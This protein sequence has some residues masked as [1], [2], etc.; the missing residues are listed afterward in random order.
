M[1]FFFISESHGRHHGRD[2]ATT[3]TDNDC[4]SAGRAAIPRFAQLHYEKI[5]KRTKKSRYAQKKYLDRR[6]AR[7]KHTPKHENTTPKRENTPQK[8]ENTFSHLRARIN[9]NEI[10]APGR[11]RR[12]ADP[13]AFRRRSA[14]VPP[15][16]RTR[17]AP[18]LH[19]IRTGAAPVPR[20]CRTGT[21][22][23]PHRC[24][25]GAALVP[26]PFRSESARVPANSPEGKK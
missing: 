5:E 17:S 20:R 19:A 18:V 4:P 1:I 21:A 6:T 2:L 10:A 22:P 15:P 24:R 7:K 3:G 16:F 26:P 9:E 8:R 12:A 13:P 23:V 25:T 11:G 14:S